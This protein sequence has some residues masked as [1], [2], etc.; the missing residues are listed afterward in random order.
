MESNKK[1]IVELPKPKPVTPH[2][3]APGTAPKE[4]K[5]LGPMSPYNAKVVP[6]E[7]NSSR[8]ARLRSS[9]NTSFRNRSAHLKK[10]KSEG[11]R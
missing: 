6:D 7:A 2:I 9:S 4:M 11:V 3:P 10:K 1:E 8:G 5:E